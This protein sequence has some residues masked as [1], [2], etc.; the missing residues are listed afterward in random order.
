MES[1]E[2]L[3][4]SENHFPTVNL[5]LKRVWKLKDGTVCQGKYCFNSMCARR[6]IDDNGNEYTSN[7]ISE[8]YD[9][10]R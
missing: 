4:I 5:D 3:P 1:I 7:M 6:W 8:Y 10:V 2:F 9:V